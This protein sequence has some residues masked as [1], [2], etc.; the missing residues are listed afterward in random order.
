MKHVFSIQKRI[1]YYYI[2]IHINLQYTHMAYIMTTR[3][4]SKKCKLK[5]NDS[6]FNF[7]I[8]KSL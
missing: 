6:H 8:K 5:L 7:E 1:M 3:I 2:R 4:N